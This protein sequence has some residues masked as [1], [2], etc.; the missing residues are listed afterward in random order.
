VTGYDPSG[1]DWSCQRTFNETP[2]LLEFVEVPGTWAL[3]ELS[4]LKASLKRVDALLF[5]Y[6]IGDPKSFEKMK[7][8]Y[9]NVVA[10]LG[11]GVHVPV[12]VV[13][14]KS[15][16]MRKEKWQVEA[17]EGRE[18][19]SRLGGVFAVCSAK[20]GEGV[21]DAVERPVTVAVEGKM[22]LLREREERHQERMEM[23]QERG[24]KSEN[25][26]TVMEKV[27]RWLPFGKQ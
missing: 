26:A 6:D 10:T 18:F 7:D 1:E 20:E 22:K 2:Y 14:A 4:A 17:E 12:G 13:A 15:D 19:A 21:E 16:M 3:E 24:R 25:T 23:C 11:E 8:I 5:V 9:E 27:R